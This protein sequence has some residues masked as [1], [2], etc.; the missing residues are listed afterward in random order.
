MKRRVKEQKRGS[1]VCKSQ[2]CCSFGAPAR[3]GHYCSP[4]EE[5]KHSLRS[6]PHQV[7]QLL[8]RSRTREGGVL[9]REQL[10]RASCNPRA[11]A[12]SGPGSTDIPTTAS[13]QVAYIF[14]LKMS[15]NF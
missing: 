1:K 2:V 9:P 5:N 11:S 8:L 12:F 13:R 7:S 14:F 4:N 15:K 6:C 10:A 3:Y